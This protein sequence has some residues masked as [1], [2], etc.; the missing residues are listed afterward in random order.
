[1][2]LTLSYGL[3]AVSAVAFVVR[4]AKIAR[5]PV[6]LRWELA[7]VPRERTRGRYGGS[8]LEEFEWWKKHREESLI[9]ELVYMLKEILLLKAL[10]EH[11]R[12]LWW[13][14]FPFHWGLYL[15][16]LAGGLTLLGGILAAVTVTVPGWGA[17]SGVLPVLAGAGY[18][19][20]TVGAVGLLAMRLVDPAVRRFTTPV[21][22]LNL[23]L[24]AAVFV[25]GVAA[26]LTTDGF[27]GL[28]LTFAWGLAT[29]H[30]PTGIPTVLAS[31]LVVTFAFLAYLPFSQMMHFVAK[32]FTYHQVRWD[33]R[34]LEVGGKIE[35]EVLGLLNRPV[36]W[37]APHVAGDGLKTWTDI[38]APEG[39][40]QLPRRLHVF[41]HQPAPDLGTVGGPVDLLLAAPLEDVAGVAAR[42]A[43][44]AVLQGEGQRLEEGPVVVLVQQLS[45]ALHEHL[46][47]DP[48]VFLGFGVGKA[49]RHH[50]V[51]V[52]D[53]ALPG[54][55][56]QLLPRRP[57]PGVVV[58]GR[59][60]DE[61]RGTQGCQDLVGPAADV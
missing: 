45:Q 61:V 11:N 53:H 17:L 35:R 19:L 21:A 36:T 60:G 13:L 33:D 32:Y 7:P 41:V 20:G 18:L 2:L 47:V 26:V 5:L 6:H 4:S 16:V 46:D 48:L 39:G 38:A 37:A 52:A 10:R 55:G 24:L 51:E 9:S 27:A 43:A 23:G 57:L 59:Q 8:Y 34:P 14:S 31:H 28:L 42:L 49:E 30:A 40:Q 3:L 15:L 1:M 56:A 44:H 12:R 29:A 58:G 22:L 25:T 50:A 54:L